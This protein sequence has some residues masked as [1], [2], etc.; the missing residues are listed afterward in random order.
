MKIEMK[1]VLILF[2][3]G[4][5]VM[6]LSHFA[7]ADDGNE[8]VKKV[9]SP[10]N[11]TAAHEAE[12]DDSNDKWD[13]SDDFKEPPF[14]PKNVTAKNTTVV[15]KSN[16]THKSNATKRNTTNTAN[17]DTTNNTLNATTNVTKNVTVSKE[18]NSTEII[19]EVVPIE[20][21]N[22]QFDESAFNKSFDD[23]WRRLRNSTPID[24]VVNIT[25]PEINLSGYNDSDQDGV[26]DMYDK[27]PGQ[28]DSLYTDSDGDGIVDAYDKYP[29]R[30]DSDYNDVDHDGV[31][32][33]RDSNIH[34]NTDKD[35]D[36]ID[37]AYDLKDDRPLMVRILS[38]FGMSK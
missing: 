9:N 17:D 11:T 2:V 7:K 30:N 26:I 1:F 15:V 34:K 32:D 36:G 23:N 6:S 16:V 25:I 21:E 38:L 5:F 14:L 37:D 35:H 12:K 8:S 27:Y 18:E 13:F 10:A 4:M 19:E 20:Q 33:S 24:V 29:G 28:N 31:P 22:I 3:V